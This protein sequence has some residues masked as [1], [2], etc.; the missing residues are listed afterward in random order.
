ME[1]ELSI[2]F[3]RHGRSGGDDEGVHEG[4]YDAPLTTVGYE[5][6]RRRAAGWQAAGIYFSAIIASPL[7]R[8]YATAQVMAETFQAPLESDP[9][10]MEFNNGPLAGLSFAEAEARYPRPAFRGP[11][12]P[13]C[14]T[15]ES[16]W[17]IHYRAARAVE[18]IVRRGPG[19]YLVVA[20][21]GILNAAMRTIV[22]AA[23]LLNGH[24]LY[25]ALGDTGYIQLIYLPQQ[26]QWIIGEVQ[27]AH[28]TYWRKEDTL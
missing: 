10:W 22:G 1:N 7:R 23:P 14:T 20:H 28:Q 25:F 16:D 3:L 18:K 2:F 15:G 4:R 27:P 21:G 19:Q 5:Q 6:V 17:E 13:F 9:D 12:E 24:G 8:A 11:Y 26:H